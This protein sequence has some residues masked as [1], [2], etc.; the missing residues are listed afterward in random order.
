MVAWTPSIHLV[1]TVHL[2]S[3]LASLTDHK[4]HKAETVFV[5][6]GAISGTQLVFRIYL[7][8][9]YTYVKV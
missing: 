2:L 1:I 3:V 4:F 5:V 8:K 9:I 6:P 7:Q